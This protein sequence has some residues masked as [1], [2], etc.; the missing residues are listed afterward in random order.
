MLPL[1]R[2]GRG[3]LAAVL[4]LTLAAPLAQ[5][6]YL[7][8]HGHGQV[9]I[10]PYYTA[11][12]GY[13]TLLSLVNDSAQA[14]ALKLRFHEGHNG[15]VV[16][17]ANLYLAPRDV[18]TGGVFAAADGRAA[19]VTDDNSCAVPDLR[20][21]PG[22][23]EL[24]DGR[25]YTPFST[26]DYSGARADGGPADAART[27]E[28]HIE[29]IEMGKLSGSSADAVVFTSN[30]GRLHPAA[31]ARLIDAWRPDGYWV[32]NAATDLA[33]PAGGLYG[34][35]TIV[36]V[37]EG[38]VFSM[39]AT[40]LDGFSVRSQHSAPDS[41]HPNLA[42]A[43]NDTASGSATAQV[44]LG[45]RTV[46]ATYPAA[47]AIDAVSAVLATA[48]SAGE[49]VWSHNSDVLTEWVLATPTKRFYVDPT[50]QNAVLGGA[51]FQARNGD[52]SGGR[53][54]QQYP[55]DYGLSR[56]DRS[57]DTMLDFSAAAPQSALCY[58]TTVV[59]VGGPH[60][61]TQSP[62]LGSRTQN[63]VDAF[64]A[65]TVSFGWTSGATAPALNGESFRGLPVIGWQL[66]NYFNGNV[67]ALMSNYSAVTPLRGDAVCTRNGA[68]C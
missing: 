3:R 67:G 57:T 34:N 44:S 2:I 59:A 61:G 13:N 50:L 26:A 63:L 56:H 1:L 48:Y 14:K 52:Q 68:D 64:E 27:R 18:W 12:A 7:N 55:G 62:V 41:A 38:L 31:C 49:S 20:N 9:L 16:F 46:S 35:A 37:A 45:A 28:G 19:L 21:A 65:G 23:P 30:G 39:P 66:V 54:C 17:S 4:A 33:A 36:D 47:R 6:V 32:A 24:P 60:I 29:V 8:P 43:V 5:A 15:R 58:D 42:D 22:L 25:S 11:N 51:P 10:Y 40:A 53:A